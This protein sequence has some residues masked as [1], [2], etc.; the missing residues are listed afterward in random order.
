MP[1]RPDAAFALFEEVDADGDGFISRDEWTPYYYDHP[2]GD[3]KL[4]PDFYF[5]PDSTRDGR[6][7]REEF[8][9]FH[10]HP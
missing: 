7:S 4:H 2:G 5:A 8:V 9:M 6:V 3:L 1:I 10:V